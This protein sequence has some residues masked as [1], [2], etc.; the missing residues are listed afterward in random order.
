MSKIDLQKVRKVIFLHGFFRRSKNPYT[1]I[2]LE[3]VF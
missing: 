1:V 2:G 3:K